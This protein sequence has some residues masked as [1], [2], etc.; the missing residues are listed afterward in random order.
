MT[1][2][3]APH[4]IDAEDARELAHP[5]PA[6]V[7]TKKGGVHPRRHHLHPV[8][9]TSRTLLDRLPEHAIGMTKRRVAKS[10]SHVQSMRPYPTARQGP[11]SLGTE[12]GRRAATRPRLSRRT[13]GLAPGLSGAGDP[14]PLSQCCTPCNGHAEERGT[15]DTQPSWALFRTPA[16]ATPGTRQGP[17]AEAGSP[18]WR[19]I[20][21][22][23]T[24]RMNP[25][26]SGVGPP[27]I[28]P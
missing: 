21:S 26:A 9:V 24:V 15:L 7:A 28:P 17:P 18:C 27:G 25:S 11:K 1:A 23:I 14:Y 12:A 8:G 4:R 10:D 3:R 2:A 6:A 13:R 22:V 16:T 20:I 5:A 19:S